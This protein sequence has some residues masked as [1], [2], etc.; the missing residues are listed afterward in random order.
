MV[1]TL[2]K[3]TWGKSLQEYQIRFS[4]TSL[5]EV[6]N[7]KRIFNKIDLKDVQKLENI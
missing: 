2:V 1:D 5:Y 6:I 4:K 7:L 3:F